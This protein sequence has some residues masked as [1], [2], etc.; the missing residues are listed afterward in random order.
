M[1]NLKWNET[2]DWELLYPYLLA[3]LVGGDLSKE[4]YSFTGD[5]PLVMNR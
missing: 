1:K 2:T 5:M 3:D 4:I